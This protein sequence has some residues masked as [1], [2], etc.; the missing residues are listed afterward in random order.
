MVKF[1]GTG[2]PGAGTGFKVEGG[3]GSTDC[4]LDLD[5]LNLRHP[6]RKQEEMSREQV[7]CL[8]ERWELEESVIR[9]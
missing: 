8:E 9:E 5:K 6:K 1:T 4:E 3:G 2:K 7:G